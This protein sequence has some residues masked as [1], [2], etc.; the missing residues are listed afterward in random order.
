MTSAARDP[1]TQEFMLEEHRRFSESRLWQLQRSFFHH[2]GTDA[3]HT[4]G[5][6][7]FATTNSF[8]ARAYARVVSGFL[9]DCAS[10]A[11]SPAYIVELG[12]G[13]GRFAFHFLSALL[14][15]L[16]RAGVETNFTYV[17]SDFTERNLEVWRSHPSFQRFFDAGILDFAL[18]DAVDPEPLR[19]ERSGVTLGPEPIG[20][21]VIVVANYVFDSIPHEL[22]SIEAGELYEQRVT[23]VSSRPEP[24]L[25]DTT[26]LPEVEVRYEAEPAEPARYGDPGVEHLLAHYRD[27]LPS[28]TFLV[29][30]AGLRCIRHFDEL[31]DGPLLMLVGDRGHETQQALLDGGGLGLAMHGSFS[32]PVNYHALD[33]YT[34]HRGGSVLRTG[35][36]RSSVKVA[37]LVFRVED[38]GRETA[39]A[40]SA[41]VDE[42]GP[43]DFFQLKKALEPIYDTLTLNQLLALLRWSNWDAN[44]FVQ[45]FPTLYGRVQS[46]DDAST[47]GVAFALRQVWDRYYPAD[48]DVDV[49]FCIASVFHVMGDHRQA[50][51]FL[52]RSWRLF[53]PDPA[54]GY[55]TALCHWHEHEMDQA[56][57]DVDEVLTLDP[58][59]EPAREMRIR[60]EA[61]L[62]DR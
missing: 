3:W 56:L 29:P 4:G 7:Q 42:L 15:I 22:F 48:G 28:A 43:D 58:D 49:A 36:H 17:M 53:G 20:N 9:A 12:A 6:P 32:L 25:A 26:F 10:P 33:L 62:A 16:R 61:A 51:H 2:R 40:F 47:R 27:A 11:P 41:W 39:R 38:G 34:T 5:V 19:L 24:D 44:L 46:G 23:L 31:A 50:L 13:S 55:L 30:L 35:G 45:T 21:P 37:G 52:D 59:C 14:P 8:I 18:F 54:T 1:G 57:A 60:I